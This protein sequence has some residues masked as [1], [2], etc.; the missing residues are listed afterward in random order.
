LGVPFASAHLKFL[1]PDRAV[2]LDS[3]ISARLDYPKTPEGYLRFVEDCRRILQ[4]INEAGLSYPGYGA[5]GWRVSDVEMAIY[6]S[7]RS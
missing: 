1:A 4:R 3:N 2:V 5:A 6:E 7:L